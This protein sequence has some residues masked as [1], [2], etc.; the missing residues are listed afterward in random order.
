MGDS[1]LLTFDK[2]RSVI[3]KHNLYS[4]NSIDN[5]ISSIKI[6]IP[7]KGYSSSYFFINEIDNVRF[8]TK[9]Y[10]YNKTDPELYNFKSSDSL[11]FQPDVEIKLLKLF[12]DSLISTNI[13]PHIISYI[14]SETCSDF[15]S[16]ISSKRSFTNPISQRVHNIFSRHN[17]LLKL[18]LIH[19]KL[20]FICMEEGDIDFRSFI[21]QYVNNNLIG[22]KLFKS[23]LFSIIFT[24]FKIRELF[25]SFRHNDLHSNNILIKFDF[26][27][28]FDPSKPKFIKY[29]SNTT[30]TWYIPY[31][32]MT[33][34]II[35]FG[36]STI[37]DLDI[38]SNIVDD[39]VF[40]NFKIPDDLLYLFYDIY[41]ILDN[42]DAVLLLNSLDP[43]KLYQN[44]DIIY[45]NKHKKLIP[46]IHSHLFHSEW[47]EYSSISPH[48]DDIL[49]IF[50]N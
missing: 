12:Y 24:L 50:G 41:S 46:T 32:G 47:N 40:M 16:L 36:F 48:S 39:V 7:H 20:S 18:H 5:F 49:H 10:F 22:F 34:K 8:F 3:S 13:T 27:F 43:K 42:I 37:T 31:F 6:I 14:H 30:N 11:L 35:D 23:L 4:C 44:T 33:P 21:L 45:I 15:S 25:P 29:T 17:D 19:N 2:I 9:L 38:K 26:S 1:K 28:V